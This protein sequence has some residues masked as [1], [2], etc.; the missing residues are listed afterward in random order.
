MVIA[1]IQKN[2]RE[3][4]R[5]ERTQFKGHDL[6]AVRVYI[7]GKDGEMK[8]TTKGITMKPEAWRELAPMLS[9]ELAGVAEP[10]D[11]GEK[12]KAPR[13]AREGGDTFNQVVKLAREGYNQA[14][15]ARALD[16]NRSTVNRHFKKAIAEGLL[17]ES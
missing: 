7:E 3:V 17:H 2:R 8:A 4:V 5:L 6:L 1:E 10:I 12:P 13:K 11:Q 9:A 14:E 16:L 15:A